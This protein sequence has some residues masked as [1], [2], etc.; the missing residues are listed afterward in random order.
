MSVSRPC[1]LRRFQWRIL[2]WLFQLLVVVGSLWQ[3]LAIAAQL[4][5]LPLSSQ[6]P[7]PLCICV[8]GSTFPFSY[9]DASHIGFRARPKQI[10]T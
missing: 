10:L 1:F 7:S 8:S 9:K 4:S 6:A 2:C 5:S 3:C